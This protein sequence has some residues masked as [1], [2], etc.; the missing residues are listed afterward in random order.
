D[1]GDKAGHIIANIALAL[2]RDDVG[3]SVRAYLDG[4]GKA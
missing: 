2:E 1:C 4:L 3:P